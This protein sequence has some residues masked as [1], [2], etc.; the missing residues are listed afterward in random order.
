MSKSCFCKGHVILLSFLQPILDTLELS[1]WFF[2][3]GSVDHFI[4][5]DDQVIVYVLAWDEHVL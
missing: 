3:S 4:F 2:G 1:Q 5:R